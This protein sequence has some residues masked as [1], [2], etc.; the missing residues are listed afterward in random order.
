M[1]HA[2]NVFEIARAQPDLFDD[3]FH[4]K[5][6]RASH[7][8][9][10]KHGMVVD[11]RTGQVRDRRK[12]DY[13]SFECPVSMANAE[14]PAVKQFFSDIML[15]DLTKVDFLQ[16]VLGACLTGEMVRYYFILHG[17]GRNGKSAVLDLMK[18]ILC[19][20]CHSVSHDV[21]VRNPKSPNTG[22]ATTHLIPLINARLCMFSE[23][24]E[25][26]KLDAAVLKMI[27]G[28]DTMTARRLVENLPSTW[29]VAETDLAT[30]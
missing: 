11:L 17:I 9:P 29:K 4:Q 7:L 5:V 18:A 8:L 27:T 13:F 24:C 21:F 30:R 23:S 2:K 16:Y 28:G 20:A 26:D 1:N 15:G 12:D 3:N 14:D 10:I 25:G 22:A 19:N 6:D